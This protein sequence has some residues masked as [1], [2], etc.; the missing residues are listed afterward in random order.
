MVLAACGV[1][2][3]RFLPWVG[4]RWLE[5]FS[6]D[7]K[8]CAAVAASPRPCGVLQWARELAKLGIDV[9]GLQLVLGGKLQL[10]EH[11][12]YRGLVPKS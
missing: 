3:K 11:R 9:L 8:R 5:G 10:S 7:Q 1:S 12:F 6:G 2:L 4:L